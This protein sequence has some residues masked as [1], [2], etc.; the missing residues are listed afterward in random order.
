[1]VSYL[2]LK[3]KNFGFEDI[4]YILTLRLIIQKSPFF[5]ENKLFVVSE[6]LYDICEICYNERYSSPMECKELEKT[7]NAIL[8]CF[9]DIFLLR[10]DFAIQ[11]FNEISNFCIKLMENDDINLL[12]SAFECFTSLIKSS[13]FQIILL[14]RVDIY[15]ILTSLV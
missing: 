12:E 5:I 8:L 6:I 10:K 2:S 7:I 15:K 1:M 3:K 14:A 9:S 11:F 13:G 4:N